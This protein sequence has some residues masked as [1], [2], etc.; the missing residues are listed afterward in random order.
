[1]VNEDLFVPERWDRIKVEL[2]NNGRVAVE[3]LADTFNVSRSTIRRDLMEMHDRGLLVRTRGGAVRAQLVAYDR[4]L[5]ETGIMNVQFKEKI[6]RAAAALIS[7][8]ETVMIDAGSTTNQVVKHLPASSIT[9]VTNSFD[10]VM[11]TMLKPDIEVI[12]LGGMVRKHGGS[13]MGPSAEEQV[14][15]FKADTAILGMNGVSSTEGLTTPSIMVAQVKRAMVKQS[16]RLIVVA[17]HT[18]L[19]VVALC[20]V[21]PIQA[22]SILVTDDEAN[23]KTVEQIRATGIEVIIAS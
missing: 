10:A 3:E 23:E 17:D 9:L 19:S 12:M 8:K 21:A 1:L 15:Q 22:A 6:G 18:K 14:C 16:K 4:P 20:K 7:L 13:T 5:S 11:A 2:D